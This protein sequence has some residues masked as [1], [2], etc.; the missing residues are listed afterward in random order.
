MVIVLERFK[1]RGDDKKDDVRN[2][3]GKRVV[4]AFIFS[5]N[6][7]AIYDSG[8]VNYVF[9][10]IEA[11]LDLQDLMVAMVNSVCENVVCSNVSAVVVGVVNCYGTFLQIYGANRACSD[12][13]NAGNYVNLVNFYD[14]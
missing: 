1:D 5:F 9:V 10:F 12:Q 3:D 14:Y 7:D 11:V 4:M 6:F 2:E 13:G 8:S